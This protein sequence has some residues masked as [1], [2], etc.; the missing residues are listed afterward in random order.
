[1]VVPNIWN[2]YTFWFKSWAQLVDWRNLSVV[3]VIFSS[4]AC[5]KFVP[6]YFQSNWK[7]E[8]LLV[9]Y[10]PKVQ[11][12]NIFE[13]K[14]KSLLHL[15]TVFDK[16]VDHRKFYIPG[17]FVGIKLSSRFIHTRYHACYILS[18]SW[19]QWCSSN[20]QV[21]VLFCIWR[22]FILFASVLSS[23]GRDSGKQR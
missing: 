2:S 15:L 10:L 22:D 11:H 4:V 9:I 19:L 17:I 21:F 1:M 5:F 16:N 7:S 8:N 3:S 14:G 20:Y 12:K 6:N 23:N 13:F 18:V